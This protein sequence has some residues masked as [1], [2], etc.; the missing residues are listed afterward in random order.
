MHLPAR[1][2]PSRLPSRAP[3]EAGSSLPASALAPVVEVSGSREQG[4]PTP[5][6]AVSAE[7]VTGRGG[8]PAT[9]RPQPAR[10]AAAALRVAKRPMLLLMVYGVCLVLVGVTA[11]AQA[12]VVTSNY[13]T[14]AMQ[15][16]VADDAALVRAVVNTYVKPSDLVPGALTSER[17]AE[18]NDL[19]GNLV[20][21][22]GI[23]RVELRTIDSRIIASNQPLPDGLVVTPNSTMESAINGRAAASLLSSAEAGQAG[24]ALSSAM[25]IREDL[26]LLTSDGTVRAVMT[27]WR[28]AQGILDEMERSRREVVLLTL[29][30]AAVLSVILFF[31][32][33][34]AQDRISR[35]TVA[36][37]EATRR[38]MS[39]GLLNHGA[40]VDLLAAAMEASRERGEALSVALVDIDNFRLVNDTHG[41]RVG[42]EALKVVAEQLRTTLPGG[43]TLGRYGPDEFLLFAQGSIAVLE[44]PVW[45]VRAALSGESLERHAG[46]RLPITISAGLCEYPADAASVTELLAVAARTLHAARASGGDAIRT[47]RGQATATETASFDILQGLVIA[48]DTKDRYT[49]R[50]SEDVARYGLFIADRMGLDI[51]IRRTIRLAGLLHDVGKIGIPDNVLRKPGRLTDAEYSI[52][53][54]H[55]ALGDMIVRDLPGIDAVR[56]G[57]RHHHERWDGRGYLHGLAGGDI[58]LVARILAV[59]DAFSAMTTNRPYRKALDIR[60]AIIRLLDA[61]GTQ[62]DEDIV[63]VFVEGLENAPNAPLPGAPTAPLWTPETLEEVAA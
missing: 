38:D 20:F 51:E 55:V 43:A 29:S 19:L 3:A 23:E 25:L 9:P 1:R 7:P 16:V 36:L 35:Q 53:K 11:S 13:Q 31:I 48:I 21:R 62:L 39:T 41:H 24:P 18:L 30:A 44:P 50:H 26:P 40:V 56:A 34:T 60:E 52:V 47:A 2:R 59:G 58:P 32:F 22:A 17:H 46:E 49:K 45:A 15:S 12:A 28:D 6:T 8:P 14:T 4:V 10:R 5:A 63:G 54:Q 27:V 37:V 33:R 57:I 61:A 42:D